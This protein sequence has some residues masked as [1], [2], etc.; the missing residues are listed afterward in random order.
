[1]SKKQ[2]YYGFDD[3]E[4][5]SYDDP[6]ECAQDRVDTHDEPKVGETFSISVGEGAPRKGSYY[7]QSIA[8]D[9]ANSATGDLPEGI[10]DW[11]WDIDKIA[12]ELQE[13]CEKAVDAILDKRKLQPSFCTLT[14]LPYLTY[15]RTDDGV[16][17]VLQRHD[18]D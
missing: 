2:T 16:E 14:K 10:E 7:L 12:D 3:G 11:C 13:A 17:R 1:M 15:R 4:F 5:H 18:H 9:M 8:D 6:D